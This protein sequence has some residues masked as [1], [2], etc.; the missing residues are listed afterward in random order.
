MPMPQPK[1]FQL[2][3]VT[4]ITLALAVCLTTWAEQAALGQQPAPAQASSTDGIAALQQRLQGS[5]N[6]SLKFENKFYKK[7]IRK[8]GDFV[9]SV[10]HGQAYFA[11]PHYF[12]WDI[13]DKASRLLFDGKSFFQYYPA[14]SSATEMQKASDFLNITEI[15]LNFDSLTKSYRMENFKEDA[16]TASLTLIPLQAS[17]LSKAEVSINK[18]DAYIQTLVLTYNDGQRNE[19]AFHSPQRDPIATSLF[20]IPADTKITKL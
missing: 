17:D 20:Q 7:S 16:K 14:T 13:E 3:K 15:F 6:L 19:I 9:V 11:K 1:K 2:L 10:T 18:A 5:G 8:K 12:R 4:G